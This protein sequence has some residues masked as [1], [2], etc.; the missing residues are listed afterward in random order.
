M[1][2]TSVPCTCLDLIAR[3]VYF[4]TLKLEVFTFIFY[5]LYIGLYTLLTERM[6][7]YTS[8]VNFGPQK[9]RKCADDGVQFERSVVH[10]EQSLAEESKLRGDGSEKQEM[11]G[12]RRL[13][14][15]SEGPVSVVGDPFWRAEAR[16]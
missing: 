14:W 10:V 16:V 7:F 8:Y 13:G 2:A 6:M 12:H 15:G 9:M 3:N 11:S 1:Y 5:K 4:S